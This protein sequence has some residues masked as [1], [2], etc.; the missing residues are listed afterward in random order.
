MAWLAIQTSCSPG[1]EP[2]WA[3]AP[4]PGATVDVTAARRSGIAEILTAAI[5]VLADLGYLGWHDA[6]ITGKRKPRGQELTPAQRAANKLQAQLRCV[7]ERG[8][9]RL[10]YWKVLVT[11]LRCGPDSALRWSRPL[12]P[13]TTWS[14]SRSPPCAPRN[15]R[16]SLPHR[17]APAACAGVSPA[18]SKNPRD[19]K[20]N[21]DQITS[22]RDGTSQN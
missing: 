8:N 12:W 13:R 14:T 15:Q 17:N 20:K 16:R 7:G 18:L 3:A 2:L 10:K 4:Q 22:N 11:E 19:Q 21:P 5:G 9:A 1:G 6:V